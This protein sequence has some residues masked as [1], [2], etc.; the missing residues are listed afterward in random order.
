MFEDDR[1]LAVDVVQRDPVDFAIAVVLGLYAALRLSWLAA[2]W[3]RRGATSRARAVSAIAA[4][5][6][7]AL[8]FGLLSLRDTKP[9]SIV[10]LSSPVT[11][12]A[13]DPFAID[14]AK[15]RPAA[16]VLAVCDV[17]CTI[18][19]A[20]W[21]ENGNRR[22]RVPEIRWHDLVATGV[23]GDRGA[24]HPGLREPQLT[25][26]GTQADGLTGR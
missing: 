14:P 19:K 2:E 20:W 22:P 7:L 26:A 6:V 3:A 8:A 15:E 1:A 13:S 9:P 4:F 25:A 10:L 16:T 5:G 23:L 18:S 21:V 12:G 24:A 11:P 17:H